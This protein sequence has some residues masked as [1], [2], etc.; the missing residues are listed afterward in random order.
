M[1]VWRLCRTR[2]LVYRA[3]ELA[4]ELAESAKR[5]KAVIAS[6]EV[7]DQNVVDWMVTSEAWHGS[8]HDTR[9]R[10]SLIDGSLILN[11]SGCVTRSSAFVEIAIPRMC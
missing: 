4:E 7:Q 8:I 5:L 9:Q 6:D 3:H 11:G 1:P 10:D 2:S